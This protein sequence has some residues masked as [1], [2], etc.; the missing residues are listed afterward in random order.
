MT[1]SVN[2]KAIRS[3]SKVFIIYYRLMCIH[4]LKYKNKRKTMR[5]IFNE[6]ELISNNAELVFCEEHL[7]RNGRQVT[8]FSNTSVEELRYQQSRNRICIIQLL[9]LWWNEFIHRGYFE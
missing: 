7:E 9:W 1:T 6:D 3:S 5:Q 8:V 4:L 2:S